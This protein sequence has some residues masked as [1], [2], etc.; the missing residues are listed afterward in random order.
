MSVIVEA[1]ELKSKQ[2]INVSFNIVYLFCNKFVYY[3]FDVIAKR[4]VTEE[5]V[6][7]LIAEGAR[8]AYKDKVL[9]K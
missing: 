5:T 6:K 9:S 7:Q 3:L 1:V 2:V 4:D 8:F